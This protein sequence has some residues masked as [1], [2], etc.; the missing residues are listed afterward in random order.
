MSLATLTLLLHAALA[1]SAEPRLFI[2]MDGHIHEL[3]GYDEIIPCITPSADRE[4]DCTEFVEI[5]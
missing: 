3:R 1:Q 5:A 2:P 4:V